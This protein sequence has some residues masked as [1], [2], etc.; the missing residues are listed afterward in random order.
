MVDMDGLLGDLV[1]VVLFVDPAAETGFFFDGD[2]DGQMMGQFFLEITGIAGLEIPF[3][4]QAHLQVGRDIGHQH[5]Q[6]V[7]HGFQQ[8]DGQPFMIGWQHEQSG[9][10]KH[11]VQ[12]FSGDVPGPDD[13]VVGIDHG[14]EPPGR[15]HGRKCVVVGSG[16]QTPKLLQSKSFPFDIKKKRGGGK[17]DLFQGKRMHL[18]S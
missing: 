4:C 16:G 11:L 3:L 1:P 8:G 2:G 10:G 15:Y 5:G 18:Q 9:M 17:P 12:R 13:D 14:L 6:A 7:A